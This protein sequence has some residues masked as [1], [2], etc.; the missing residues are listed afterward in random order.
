MHQIEM[1][2]ERKVAG[3]LDDNVDFWKHMRFNRY[4][5][6]EL[7]RLCYSSRRV[8]FSYHMLCAQLYHVEIEELLFVTKTSASSRTVMEGHL[9]LLH[10][11]STYHSSFNGD[12]TRANWIRIANYFKN[13]FEKPMVI[14]VADY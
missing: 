6:D 14:E 7:L 9:Q 8:K 4:G 5:N 3:N 12:E 13:T 1:L 2:K 11:D 10:S